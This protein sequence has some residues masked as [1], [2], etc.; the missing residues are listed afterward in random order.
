MHLACL[1]SYVNLNILMR[2]ASTNVHFDRTIIVLGYE[3]SIIK[4]NIYRGLLGY[5][6]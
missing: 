2:N 1:I 4:F 6:N 5:T 3:W